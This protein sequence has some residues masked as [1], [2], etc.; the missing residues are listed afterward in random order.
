VAV[1]LYEPPGAVEFGFAP[2]QL[3]ESVDALYGAVPKEKSDVAPSLP[4][5]TLRLGVPPTATLVVPENTATAT[6]G[7]IVVFFCHGFAGWVTNCNVQ[8]DTVKVGLLP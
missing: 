4:A 1:R 7:E 5:A 3:H 2:G 8:V 6:G